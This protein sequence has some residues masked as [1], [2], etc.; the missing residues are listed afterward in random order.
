MPCAPSE[1]RGPHDL[2][3]LPRPSKRQRSP[4]TCTS[5][6][7]HPDCSKCPCPKEPKTALPAAALTCRP[8]ASTPMAGVSALNVRSSWTAQPSSLQPLPLRCQVIMGVTRTACRHAT[9]GL[10]TSGTTVALAWASRTLRPSG[11]HSVM[12]PSTCG[13]LGRM[14]MRAKNPTSLAGE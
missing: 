4:S 13:S 3:R 9:V 1:R 5:P 8:C 12:K 6:R 10:P 2:S 11:S 14:A 7:Q